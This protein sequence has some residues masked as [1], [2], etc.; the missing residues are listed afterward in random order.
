MENFLTLFSP[1]RLFSAPDNSISWITQTYFNFPWRFELS[2][3]TV[4]VKCVHK[5]IIKIEIKEGV[6]KH[7]MLKWRNRLQVR[8]NVRYPYNYW[9][10]TTV[11]S[12]I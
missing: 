5:I 11:K 8:V 9:E 1:G 10:L 2:E 7:E 4:F 3:A 6:F 12:V